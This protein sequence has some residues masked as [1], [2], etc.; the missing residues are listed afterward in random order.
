MFSQ[1]DSGGANG[2]GGCRD[3]EEGAD[4]QD[5]KDED[6]DGDAYY[7]QI[8]GVGFLRDLP[9]NNMIR[10]KGNGFNFDAKFT[11]VPS[12]AK[13][14]G[15]GYELNEAFHIDGTPDAVVNFRG[16]I[17]LRTVQRQL[18]YADTFNDRMKHH[19]QWAWHRD[20][21]EEDFDTFYKPYL[22]IK[23]KERLAIP[24]DFLNIDP[25]HMYTKAL[26]R[27][28]GYEQMI[29]NVTMKLQK[30]PIMLMSLEGGGCWKEQMVLITS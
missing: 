10:I 16:A 18:S 4:H 6:G 9:T 11:L 21:F 1:F 7:L 29:W 15:H 17:N 13:E 14:D 12:E 3:E 23:V 5:D 2:S 19:C 20:H 27:H 26:M 28:N 25:M 8:L 30:G 24:S 22:E